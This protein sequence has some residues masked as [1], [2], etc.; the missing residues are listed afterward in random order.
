MAWNLVFHVNGR[1]EA[2]C[3]RDCSGGYAFWP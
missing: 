3:G 1:M 2:E